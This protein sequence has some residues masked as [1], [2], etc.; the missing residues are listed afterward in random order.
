MKRSRKILL[1]LA[2]V[3]VIFLFIMTAFHIEAYL[4]HERL[5][6][7]LPF[8][9]QHDNSTAMIPMGETLFHPKPQVPN[10][11]PGIDFGWGHSVPVIASAGGTVTK[12]NHGSSNGIDVTVRSGVYELRYKEL[13][14]NSLGV[15][16][17]IGSVIKK[18]DFIGN[19]DN[20]T[21]P[22][23]PDRYQLHWEFASV[24]PFLDRFCPVTYFDTDSKARIENIWNNVKP[25]DAQ[26]MK[27][28]FPYICSG[29]YF[30]K[31][32]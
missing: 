22:A 9:A 24:S 16:I 2:I 7:S 5:I 29:D 17:K 25:T 28:Q 8:A 27:Q 32:E 10:G 31:Q 23:S 6:I 4:P 12:I 11:H 14:T 1:I 30:N 20:N 21:Q 26:N 3:V 13:A 18:G 19:P 15:N